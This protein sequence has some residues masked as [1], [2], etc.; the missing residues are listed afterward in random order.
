MRYM[1]Y[2]GLKNTLLPHLRQR[3]RSSI[4]LLLCDV[5]D[6]KDAQFSDSTDR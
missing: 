5:R 6:L 1:R 2:V 4:H 3:Q